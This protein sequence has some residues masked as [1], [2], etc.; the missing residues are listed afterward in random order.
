MATRPH[1]RVAGVVAPV[2]SWKESAM[3]RM[4][5]RNRPG[6]EGLEDRQLLNGHFEKTPTSNVYNGQQNGVPVAFRGITYTAPTGAKVQLQ[7][8][9]NGS[10]AG[11]TLNSQGQLDLVYSGTNAASKIIINVH[12][13]SGTAPLHSVRPA[14]IAFSNYTG[15][16]GQILGSLIAPKVDLVDQGQINLTP[17]IGRLQLH[18]IGH[19]TQIHLRELP[20]TVQPLGVIPPLNSV[21]PNPKPLLPGTVGVSQGTRNTPTAPPTYSSSGRTLGYSNDGNGGSTLTSVT[22]QFAATLNQVVYP[23]PTPPAFVPFPPGIIIQ[24]D[25]INAGAPGQMTLGNGQTP[26][27]SSSASAAG[28]ARRGSRA[29]KGC[30]PGGLRRGKGRGSR[31]SRRRLIRGN[32]FR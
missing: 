4:S 27:Q 28:S 24:V 29:G 31:L 19:N 32:N 2:L 30:N 20:Q 14:N 3:T 15:I 12:G 1:E 7:V 18:S 25:Q 6:F 23:G 5:K 22:G 9:G 21:N 8:L 10:I 16:G 17:G 26:P 11:T 13:G